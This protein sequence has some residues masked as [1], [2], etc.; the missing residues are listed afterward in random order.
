[1]PQN[2]VIFENPINIEYFR[3]I[4]TSQAQA[5]I[6]YSSSILP[7]SHIEVS[8]IIGGIH[9]YVRAREYTPK[10]TNKFPPST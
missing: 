5:I 3:W 2:M 7:L 10:V 9:P 1:M 6:G 4:G 8:P